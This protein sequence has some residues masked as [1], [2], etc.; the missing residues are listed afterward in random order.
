LDGKSSK[1]RGKETEDGGL[2]HR[3]RFGSVTK[4]VDAVRNAF[5]K[6]EPGVP[7]WVWNVLALALGVVGALVFS[8]EP[9]ELKVWDAKNP[10]TLLTPH[11]HTRV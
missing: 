7:K 5:G 4:I 6:A 10:I 11:V 9:V 1:S 8:I 2:Y 3:R